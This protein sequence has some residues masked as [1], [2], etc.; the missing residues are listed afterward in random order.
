MAKV[1]AV[2]RVY[3]KDISLEM[4]EL[5]EKIRSALPSECQLA[6]YEVEEIGFGIKLLKA[7]ILMPEDYEGGTSRIEE[8]LSSLDEVSQIEEEYVTRIS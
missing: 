4:T 8:A 5:A 2:F 1:M 6:K 7:Y 3:P